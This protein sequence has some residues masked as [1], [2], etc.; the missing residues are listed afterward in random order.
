MCL[1]RGKASIE[2]I[3]NLMVKVSAFEARLKSYDRKQA[4]NLTESAVGRLLE[5]LGNPLLE[6][7]A[8][9][10]TS[11]NSNVDGMGQGNFLLCPIQQRDCTSLLKSR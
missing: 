10:K 1:S 7:D 4:E 5:Y 8:L 6:V 2:T 9:A 11:D 3:R